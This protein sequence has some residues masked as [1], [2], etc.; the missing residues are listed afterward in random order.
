M[1]F[2]NRTLLTP[3]KSFSTCSSPFRWLAPGAFGATIRSLGDVP[4]FTSP[5]VTEII[6]E[7]SVDGDGSLRFYSRRAFMI[8]V[9]GI[10]ITVFDEYY[11]AFV[12]LGDF[13]VGA[14]S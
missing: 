7:S 9:S 12:S 3:T 6:D 10:I 13:P 2:R 4:F 8:G 11:F 1:I 5:I 14:I